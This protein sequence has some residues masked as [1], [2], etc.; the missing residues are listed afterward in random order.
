MRVLSID[1]GFEKIGIAILEKIKN[2]EILKYSEC[3]YTSS[4]DKFENRILLIG[5][6]IKNIIKE[7]KPE[8]LAIETLFFNSNQKTAMRVSEARGVIIYMAKSAGLE[9]YEYTPLQVKIAS[10]GYGR[11]TKKQVD[12]MVRKIINI[13][14][15]IIKDDEMDAIAIGITCLASIP[16]CYPQK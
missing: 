4:S 12:D 11:A 7:W 5:A 6:H 8:A 1:P 9:I 10:T 16:T 14:K 15:T 3:F 2:K 13:E